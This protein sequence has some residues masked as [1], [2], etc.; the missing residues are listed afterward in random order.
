MAAARAA[1]RFLFRCAVHISSTLRNT[2]TEDGWPGF[3]A[4][5]LLVVMSIL[6][7]IK[8]LM[9]SERTQLP[10]SGVGSLLLSD[11]SGFSA[12]TWEI[13]PLELIQVMGRILEA[14]RR[15]IRESDGLMPYTG[16]GE[17]IL[18]VWSSPSHAHVAVETARKILAESRKVQTG[19]GFSFQVRVAVTTGKM[20][21]D[22][23][24]GSPQ[25]FGP[26]FT[27]AKRLLDSAV[28]RRSNV[29]CTSETL[30]L[31]PDRAR[32][33]SIAMIRGC[34]GQEV[35]VFEFT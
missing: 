14:E 23:I 30:E 3:A 22:T 31:V 34:S 28:P 10:F 11:T 17:V 12:A 20:T 32:S 4:L 13:Y 7:S 15:C 9:S 35:P 27:T 2:A 26:P 16:V 1:K 6:A 8:S 18:G 33:D 29:L 21:V 5:W 24:G 19:T 25:V